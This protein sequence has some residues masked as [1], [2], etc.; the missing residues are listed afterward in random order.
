MEKRALIMRISSS[1]A[2]KVTVTVSLVCAMAFSSERS[3]ASNWNAEYTRISDEQT[4]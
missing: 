2:K 4:F 3:I 1:S